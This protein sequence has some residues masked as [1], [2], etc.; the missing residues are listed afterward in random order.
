M[1]AFQKITE[2]SGIKSIFIIDNEKS[3]NTSIGV[4]MQYNITN[5]NVAKE[6]DSINEITTRTSD[7]AF[8]ARD[9]I[10]LLEHSGISILTT[11]ETS[12]VR[13]PTIK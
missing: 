9:L 7:M 3:V 8:D 2:I 10:T 13:P 12:V 5:V 11:I 1:E 6:F 4:K